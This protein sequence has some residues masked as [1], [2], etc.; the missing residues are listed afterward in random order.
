[1]GYYCK[2][3]VIILNASGR[4]GTVAEQEYII[5]QVKLAHNNN[6]K[7]QLLLFMF[8]QESSSFHGFLSLFLSIVGML[9]FLFFFHLH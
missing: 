3:L 5:I 8:D 6:C 1:M 4:I 7:S 2:D 9:F